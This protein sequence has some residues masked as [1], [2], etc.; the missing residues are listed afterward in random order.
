MNLSQLI[1]RIKINCGLYS[2]ALPFENPDEVIMDVIQN[3]TLRTFS[4]Y[5]PWYQTIRLDLHDLENIEKKGNEEVYLLPDIFNKNEILFIK[6]VRYDDSSIS[7]IG[8]WGAGT[9]LLSRNLISQ[10]ILSNAAMN[11][12]N[13]MIPKITFKFEHPRKVTLYNPYTSCKIIFEI[14]LMHDKNLGSISPTMEESFFELAILDVKDMLYQSMKHYNEIQTAFGN[15]NLKIDE[16]SQASSDR[17]Q[18][19]DEWENSYHIDIVPFEWL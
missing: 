7:N 18:L 13:H 17:K 10:G 4:T 1:T 8:Y 6:E 11:L 3:I 12:T 15:I 2:I 16:W 5:S 9:P 14:A 19:L